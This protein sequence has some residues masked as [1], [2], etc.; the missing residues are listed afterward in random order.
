MWAY[1]FGFCGSDPACQTIDTEHHCYIVDPSCQ[2]SPISVGANEDNDDMAFSLA[3]SSLVCVWIITTAV[4][5]FVYWNK[6][7]HWATGMYKVYI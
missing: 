4:L 2:K 7:K 1:L 6:R 3:I 5:V